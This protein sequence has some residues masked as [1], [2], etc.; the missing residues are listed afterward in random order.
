[1]GVC[2][3][4]YMGIIVLSWRLY[5]EILMLLDLSSE[6]CVD[7]RVEGVRSSVC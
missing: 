4:P 2:L 5:M 6:Q 7:W 3:R 1:M